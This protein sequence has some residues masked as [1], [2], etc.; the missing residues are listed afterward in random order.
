MGT[1]NGVRDFFL[2]PQNVLKL[3][4]G[5]AAQFCMFKNY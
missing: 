4:N 1:V 3:D 2:E 5:A